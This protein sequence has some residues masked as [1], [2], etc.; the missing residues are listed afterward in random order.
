MGYELE[1]TEKYV[2]DMES[3]WNL[4]LQYLALFKLWVLLRH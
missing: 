3:N 2:I 4:N 1:P